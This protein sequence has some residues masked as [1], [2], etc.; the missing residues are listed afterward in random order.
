[1]SATD[2]RVNLGNHDGEPGPDIDEWRIEKA[3]EELVVA[4]GRPAGW[5]ISS[6]YEREAWRHAARRV[7]RAYNDDVAKNFAAA[8]RAYQA[9]PL[10]FTETRTLWN[11]ATLEE[12][13]WWLRWIR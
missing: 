13:E 11:T 7:V 3:A 8:D 10:R 6:E 12:K 5:V 4:A 1:M 2:E 9:H